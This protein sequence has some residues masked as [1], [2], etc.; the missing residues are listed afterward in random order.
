MR[1]IKFRFWDANTKV[2]DYDRRY[3]PWADE[4]ISVDA[5]FDTSE[6]PSESAW[7]QYTGLKD[8]DGIEV[9][10]GD[11]LKVYELSRYDSE[12][13]EVEYTS[14]VEYVDYG[15]LVTEPCKTQVPLACFG[16]KDSDP[17]FEI[18]VIG[19]IYENP[20]LLSK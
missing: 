2:M 11:V 18:K 15:F 17:L 12:Y 4:E 7:L 9:Y 10:E 1:E 5:F 3:I 16:F 20:E 8:R 13:R 14:P 6:E 19:N